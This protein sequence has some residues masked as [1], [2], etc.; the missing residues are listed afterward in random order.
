[1][2]S[3]AIAKPFKVSKQEVMQAWHRVK[4]NR[5]SGGVDGISLEDFEQNLAKNLYKLWNRMSSGSYKPQA[6]KRVEIPKKDGGVRAL[7]IPTV[8]DRVAQDVVR[9]RLEPRVEPL[10]DE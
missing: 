6:V 2:T 8:I 5:G 4:A 9:A 7:G 10:F 1:M 3:P